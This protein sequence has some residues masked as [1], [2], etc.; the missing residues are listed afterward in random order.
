MAP[1]DAAGL[2]AL[3]AACLVAE[4]RTDAISLCGNEVIMD[5]EA[6]EVMYFRKCQAWLGL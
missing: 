2:L 4:P 1:P 5:D 6:E 3:G